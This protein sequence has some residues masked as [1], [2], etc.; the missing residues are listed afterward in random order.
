MFFGSLILLLV[1]S[2]VWLWWK[3]SHVQQ[4]NVQLHA[5]LSKLRG[6][7]RALRQ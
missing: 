2:S 4:E 5:E 1:C 7:A 6:R 3:L